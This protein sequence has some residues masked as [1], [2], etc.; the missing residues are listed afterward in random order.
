MPVFGAKQTVDSRSNGRSNELVAVTRPIGVYEEVED[1]VQLRAE[2][3]RR[4]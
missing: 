3:R 1:A 4:Q 2:E